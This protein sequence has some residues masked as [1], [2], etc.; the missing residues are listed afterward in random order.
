MSD[1]IE[2]LIDNGTDE[3]CFLLM[4][5]EAFRKTPAYKEYLEKKKGREKGEEKA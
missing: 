4:E 1:Y 2:Y 3:F 5:F